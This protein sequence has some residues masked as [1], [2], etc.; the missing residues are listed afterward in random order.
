MQHRYLGRHYD[1]HNY[2]KQKIKSGEG[3][4]DNYGHRAGNFFDAKFGKAKN[5]LEVFVGQRVVG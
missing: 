2:E 5:K 4:A 3:P 1:R